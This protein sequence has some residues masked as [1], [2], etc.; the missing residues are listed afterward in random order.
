MEFAPILRT[1]LKNKVS[2]G[3][4]V[5]EI[6]I[7]TTI[8]LNAAN[9][10]QGFNRRITTQSGIAEN[11]IFALNV[12]SYG[13]QYQNK[14]TY[15][16]TVIDDLRLMKEQDGVV[17]ATAISNLPLI[18][19]GSS[20]QLK[21]ADAGEEALLR[22]PR[23]VV[24]PDFIETLGLEL[25]AGRTF[26]MED[27]KPPDM[28]EDKQD[29]ESIRS[30]IVTQ[31]FADDHFKGEN[32]L[33][34]IMSSGETQYTIIGIIKYMHTP[35][36]NGKSGMEFRSIF[37]PG[38]PGD[39]SRTNYL[40]RVKPAEFNRLF[41]EMEALLG[42]ARSERIVSATAL[43]EIRESGFFFPNFM[44]FIVSGILVL[45]LL[46]TAL[47]IYGMTSFDVA[48]R[49]RQIGVRRA[50][51]ATRW[52]IMR[53]FLVENSM[54]TLFGIALGAVGAYGLNILM[55]STMSA[56]G[57]RVD[58]MVYGILGIWMVGIVSTLL[59][60]KKASEVPPAIAT[61]TV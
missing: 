54:V 45:L 37:F 25:V 10:I 4:L 44:V 14:T 28:E 56:D 60:A 55:M 3:L 27:I 26:T 53:Y 12:E 58:L 1:L 52:E 7:F 15:F 36:D 40:V 32:A 23:Y 61:R 16:Q 43:L 5:V 34:K 39:A 20:T 18:G 24:T 2:T 29:S 13:E 41:T 49:T 42:S 48:R 22:S 6:A 33:G 8:I 57:L 9:L 47:G 21:P 46:V 17:S 11:E 35:Y 50:L 59:P 51:G 19:G 38:I 31:K 30:I